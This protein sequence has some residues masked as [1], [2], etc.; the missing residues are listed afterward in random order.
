MAKE[1]GTGILVSVSQME[2]SIVTDFTPAATADID[3]EALLI[4]LRR[5]EGSWVEWGKACQQLQKAG[6]G[7]QRIF[8]ETGFEPIQQNQIVVAAQ[9][10]ESMVAAGVDSVTQERYTRSGS[11]SLYELRI[12]SRDDRSPAA[13]FL[14]QR[15]ID[16][17]GAKEVAKAFWEFSRL[18]TLPAGFTHHP[19][20]AVAYKYWRYAKQESDLAERSRSIARG[21]MFAHSQS[22]RSQIEQ[23]LSTIGTSQRNAPLLPWYRIES[24]T[25]F[26]R[27]I[28]VAG[29]LPL[30][31]IDYQNTLT[32]T[33]SGAFRTISTTGD[34]EWVALPNWRTIAKSTDLVAIFAL[35]KDLPGSVKDPEEEVLLIVD[36]EPGEWEDKNH[37]L[38][39]VDGKLKI[40]WFADRPTVDILGRLAIVLRPPRLDI[41]SE[42]D[43][44]LWDLQE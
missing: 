26:L 30:A 24:E 1:R 39:A 28:P 5:K 40:E 43:E 25:D 11:D 2:K 8:E 14:H 42:N 22:A 7:S 19:G 9:V 13:E 23:L 36:R 44:G 38:S 29:S 17:E 35:A 4:L 32:L 34:R 33:V 12:L 21:L 10:Y 16:S 18:S 20:D 6:I 31:T 3:T 41:E 15:N 37:Y 27:P